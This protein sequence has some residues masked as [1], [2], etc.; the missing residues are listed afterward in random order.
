MPAAQDGLADVVDQPVGRELA[1]G[2]VHGHPQR[3]PDDAR[4]VED[5]GLA[6]GLEEQ[7]AAERHDEAGL[8]RE[9]DELGR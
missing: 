3:G 8:L 6:A 7:V 1:R 9:R 5:G 2:H 4:R